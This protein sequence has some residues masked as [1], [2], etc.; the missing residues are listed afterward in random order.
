[1]AA[2]TYFIETPRREKTLIDS[3]NCPS[4]LE[5]GSREGRSYLETLDSVELPSLKLCLE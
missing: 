5:I 4:A 3:R 1:M 2:G